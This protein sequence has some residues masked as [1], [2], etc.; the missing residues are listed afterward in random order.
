MTEL[1]EDFKYNVAISKLMVFFREISKFETV[2]SVKMFKEVV[3]LLS[4]FAP[5]ISEEI[6]EKMGEGQLK[7]QS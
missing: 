1:I 7:T 6:L 3:I 4:V 5:H 2:I